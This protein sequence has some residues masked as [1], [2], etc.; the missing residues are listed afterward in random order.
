MRIAG[1]ADGASLGDPIVVSTPKNF[2]DAMGVFEAEF[3]K[4]LGADTVD[5]VAGGMSALLDDGH[6]EILFAPNLPEWVGKPIGETLARI[7]GGKVQI[8]NDVVM[9]ALG[10]AMKGA[11]VGFE[12]VAYLTVSTG[13]N[14]SR[15]LSG[16]VDRGRH[17]FEIGQQIIDMES[18][19][20]LEDVISG[21]A[22]AKKYG[23]HPGEIMDSAVWDEVAKNTAIGVN[24]LILHW[25]PDVVVIGGSMVVKKV[26]ISVDAVAKHLEKMIKVKGELPLIK[27]AMLGDSGGLFGSLAY[28]RSKLA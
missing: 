5:G 26:G 14:G 1:S 3:K 12:Q 4:L 24:N 7:A 6:N 11:G 20:T 16:R 2:E 10:E 19:A 15:I 21:T 23:K 28:L 8:D 9:V 25:S 18:L 27:K 13:V 22:I 17:G